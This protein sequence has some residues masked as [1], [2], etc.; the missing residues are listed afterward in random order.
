MST[1]ELSKVIGALGALNNGDGLT[2]TVRLVDSK[3][4]YGVTRYLVEPMAGAGQVWVNAHRVTL[5]RGAE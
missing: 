4:A 2:V 5:E 1:V 3:S